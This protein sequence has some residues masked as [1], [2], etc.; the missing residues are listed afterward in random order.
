M[1]Y[2]SI[3]REKNGTLDNTVWVEYNDEKKEFFFTD[4]SMINHCIQTKSLPVLLL[5]SDNHPETVDS[6]PPSSTID[7]Q[8]ASS[9]EDTSSSSWEDMS[10]FLRQKWNALFNPPPNPSF[11]IT[12]PSCLHSVT[13]SSE[14]I[15]CPTCHHPLP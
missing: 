5:F 6:N 15:L 8:L 12:C 1:H 13:I 9:W 11:T 14:T 4:A 3:C 2:V 7:E 10:S